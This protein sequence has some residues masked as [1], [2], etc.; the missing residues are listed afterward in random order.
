MRKEKLEELHHL[1]EELKTVNKERLF[2]PCSFLKSE[3]YQ[4]YLNNG[5]MI[6]REKIIKGE[7]EGSAV[8]I[9]PVIED[10]KVIL[11]VEPRVFSKRT[12]GIGLPAG[13]IEKKEPSYGAAVRELEEEIGYMPKR[14]ISLGGFYQD[15][16][17]S[18]AYNE[19]FLAL[20]CYK[21]GNQHLDEGEYIKYFNCY[22]DEALELINMGYIE[23]CNAIITLERAKKY[24]KVRNKK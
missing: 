21:A 2:E 10:D 20:D 4:C 3:V 7:K 5:Q 17:C 24:M 19:C 8:I 1:I 12:V 14:L 15:M 11:I 23:G 18:S 22:Y 9:L 16:G 13:Y 6:K